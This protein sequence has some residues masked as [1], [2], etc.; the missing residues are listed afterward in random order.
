MRTVA[1]AGIGNVANWMY[2]GSL[3]GRKRCE[4]LQLD[5]ELAKARVVERLEV[6]R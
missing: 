5:E 3:T 4:K 6:F 1:M 2:L